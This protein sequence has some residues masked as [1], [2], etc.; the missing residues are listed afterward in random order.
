MSKEKT[1]ETTDKERLMDGKTNE[2]TNEKINETIKRK[3]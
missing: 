2:T 1:N 3:R